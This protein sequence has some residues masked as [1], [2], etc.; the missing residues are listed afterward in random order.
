VYHV[1]MGCYIYSIEGRHIEKSL[2]EKGTPMLTIE[3]DYSTEDVEQI[4]T[5][6]EAFLEMIQ[7][8]RAL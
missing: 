8:Q 3:T 6:I 2:M 4:R 7:G 5:R 1:L